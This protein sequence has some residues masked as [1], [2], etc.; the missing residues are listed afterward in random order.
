M[1]EHPP[2]PQRLRGCEASRTEGMITE[3]LFSRLFC[4]SPTKGTGGSLPPHL[5]TP[6]SENW[7]VSKATQGVPGCTSLLHN[8]N[9]LHPPPPPPHTHIPFPSLSLSLSLSLS[10][11]TP[12]TRP[13]SLQLA[14]N[15]GLYYFAI[16]FCSLRARTYTCASTHAR[17]HTRGSH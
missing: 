16:N 11:P 15:N 5:P 12:I 1:D 13:V 7:L 9:L 17:T 14:K 8:A 3:H 6:T 4:D 10:S 2:L